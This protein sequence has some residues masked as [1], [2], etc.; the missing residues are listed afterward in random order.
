MLKRDSLAGAVVYYDGVQNDARTN[1]ALALTAIQQG[2]D[3]VNYAEVVGLQ[4]EMQAKDGHEA[5]IRGV[6]VKD[7]LTG[8]TFTIKCHGVINAAGPF[9]GILGQLH[10][11]ALILAI[12]RWDTQPG[13]AK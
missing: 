2:A 8:Q 1:V 13:R 10:V 11:I 3:A 4:K 7:R 9:C 6:L 5:R 12:D